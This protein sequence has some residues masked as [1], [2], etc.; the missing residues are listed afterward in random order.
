MTEPQKFKETDIKKLSKIVA[1]KDISVVCRY[2]SVTH[3]LSCPLR[4][5]S[6]CSGAGRS[7]RKLTEA[8]VHVRRRRR[9]SCCSRPGRTS[10]RSSALRPTRTEWRNWC[11]RRWRRGES[12]QQRMGWVGGNTDYAVFTLQIFISQWQY[13]SVY[14]SFI[15]M[16]VRQCNATLLLSL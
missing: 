13:C 2:G 9:G 16:A 14:S 7:T 10:S 3:S 6:D 15:Y 4:V 8:Y 11:P 1:Y 12:S 5:R